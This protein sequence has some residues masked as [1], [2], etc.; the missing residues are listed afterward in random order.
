MTSEVSMYRTGI[1]A[2]CRIRH[3][4][5]GDFGDETIPHEH[6]YLVEWICTVSELDEFGFGVNIDVLKEKLGD[7][8]SG[9]S[10][11]MLND[12]PFFKGK[13]T[14]IENTA[15]HLCDSLY[16]V[17]QQEGYPLYTMRKWEIIVRESADAWASYIRTEF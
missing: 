2:S 7:A 9:I 15:H 3:H 13:Q 5:I 4:L 17:L 16:E 1:T 12:L 11:R 6:D 8:I 14:S 10:G